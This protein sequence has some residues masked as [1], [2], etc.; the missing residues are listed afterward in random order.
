M[1]DLISK[2]PPRIEIS[3]RALAD[4]EEIWEHYSERGESA[5]EK[6]MKQITETFSR[7][8]KFPKIGRERNEL[9]LGLRSFPAGNFVIFYQETNF[10]IEIVRVARGSRDIRQMFEDMIPLEP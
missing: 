1:S 7:M 3:N 6:V 2:N 10:G 5:A 8:L 4:L 9:L